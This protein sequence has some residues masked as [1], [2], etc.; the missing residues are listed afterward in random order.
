M[1]MLYQFGLR[2]HFVL[3][4]Y[5]IIDKMAGCGKKIFG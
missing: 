2:Y 3:V 4:H 5:D 1:D